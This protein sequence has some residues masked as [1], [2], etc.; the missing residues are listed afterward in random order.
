MWKQEG[1]YFNALT[2]LPGKI[3]KT[4]AKY[5]SGWP[6]LWDE[7]QIWDLASTKQEC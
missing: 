7:N 1:A 6:S 4:Y 5:Q 3:E 2:H